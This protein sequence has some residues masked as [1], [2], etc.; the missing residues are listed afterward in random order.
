MKGR[1]GGHG[2]ANLEGRIGATNM[3]CRKGDGDEDAQGLECE[4][5]D[6]AVVALVWKEEKGPRVK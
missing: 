4:K 5:G 3:K 2:G 1:N 6:G